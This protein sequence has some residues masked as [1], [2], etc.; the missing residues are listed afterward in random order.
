[1]NRVMAFVEKR[2]QIPGVVVARQ[3]GG[4]H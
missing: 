1:V 3:N 4:G 2:L